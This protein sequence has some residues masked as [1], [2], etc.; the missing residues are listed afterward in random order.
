MGVQGG[1]ITTD[2]IKNGLV[3]NMDA[4]NR[5]STIPSTSTTTTFN[6]VNTNISGAFSGNA[7][8]DSSTIS[9]SYDFDGVDD[10]IST[11]TSFSNLS[12]STAFSISIWYNITTAT[13]YDFVIGA[14]TDGGAWNTGF[15]FFINGTN[16]LRFWVD[17]W[18]DSNQYIQSSNLNTSQWYNAIGT[19]STTSGLKLYINADISGTATGT[20]IDGLTNQIFIGNSYKSTVGNTYYSILGNIGSIQ[21][22]NRALSASEILHNYNALKGRF[23]L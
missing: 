5:A 21:I 2:I 4:A 16:A 12:V 1:S 10:V 9:P 3:F 6:T 15:G 11:N 8:Y 14:P 7:Q 22:Y 20:A 13:L 17:G 23:G 18:N 19:F